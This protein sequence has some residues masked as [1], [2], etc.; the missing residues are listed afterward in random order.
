[1]KY[2]PRNGTA[3]GAKEMVVFKPFGFSEKMSRLLLSRGLNTKEKVE[4]FF[5]VS[6]LRLCDPFLLKGMQEAKSR[7]E[8]AISLKERILIIGDYDADGICSVAILYK[9][10]I[11][12]HASTR[13]FLPNRADDGYGLNI[14]LI[15]SLK[16]R[17]EP[18]LIITV[19]CGIS[20]PDEIEH[21]KSL[22]I[23]CIVTDHHS[24][25]EKTPNCVC[26]N[27]KFEDQAYPFRDLCGAGVALKVVH[28][29]G[30]IDASARYLDICAIA[31]VADIVP[32]RGENRVIT[33]LGL[34]MLNNNSLPSVTALARSCNITGKIRSSDISFK[35]GPKINASGRMGNAKR[36]L[37]I[38]L[39]QREEE[40]GKIIRHLADYNSKRQKLCN[41]IYEQ[42]EETI[43]AEKLYKNNIIIVADKR[44]E[45]G[46]LGI[47][48]ARI[49]EKYGKPSIVFGISGDV[50]KGS[51]RS[52][53]GIDI[54]RTVGLFSK[55]LIS[56]G[57]HAMASGLSVSVKNYPKFRDD[58]TKYLNENFENL[59]ITSEKFYDFAIEQS[60]MTK[61][62]LTEI[63]KLEPTGCDNPTPV[64][65]TTIGGCH[66]SALPN[67]NKHLK[68]SHNGTHFIFFNG[69]EVGDVLAHNFPKKVIFEFQK[70]DDKA[71]KAVCK[72]IIP[73]PHDPKSYAL[74]MYGHLVGLFAYEPDMKYKS[75]ISDLSVDRDVFVEYYKFMKKGSELRAFNPYDLFVKLDGGADADKYNLYQFVFCCAVFRQLGI[76]S[77]SSEGVTIDNTNPTDLFA[78]SAY[79]KVREQATES[80]IKIKINTDITA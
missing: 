45:S 40:I 39:E 24:I 53:E 60:E 41:M 37:D 29:L 59:S 10:L 61:E 48:S 76:L 67:F 57:G 54:V 77:F 12:R 18:K 30:G 28:A 13:Y 75:I 79:N 47:V 63:D 73:V 26:I 23:D 8:R 9:Y 21:A 1:M 43:E 65:M 11:S 7:I 69:A 31:T 56:H 36:G 14:E 51:G 72:N 2:R 22:G 46:V 71:L 52:I 17:F 42:V 70:S 20:C 68:F 74:T 15:D 27:P 80:G 25:P 66:I 50:V 6:L 58:I 33:T 19:D 16:E 38:I 35:I 78:S 64:F 49:T 34:Q 32:L 44:W 3:L 5:N 55:Q 62:F 4:E